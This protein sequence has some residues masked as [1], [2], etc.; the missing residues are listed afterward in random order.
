[1]RQFLTRAVWLTPILCLAALTVVLISPYGEFPLNDDWV[2]YGMVRDMVEH[3]RLAVHPYSSAYAAAQVV[4]AAPIA[5][6]FGLSFTLLRV[7]YCQRLFLFTAGVLVMLAP[8]N[9]VQPVYHDRYIL[10]ALPMF[11]ILAAA[12]LPARV[13]AIKPW[14]AASA[15]FRPSSSTRSPLQVSRITWHGTKRVGTPCTISGPPIRSATITSMAGTS[16]TAFT[17]ANGQS[18]WTTPNGGTRADA[19]VGL[20]RTRFAPSGCAV[21]RERS[22]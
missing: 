21:R 17:R 10:P 16:S 15:R 22:R 6:L 11:A 8:I 1:M 19:T 9:A 4:L 12:A 7:R 14:A 18:V 2:Y 5:F 3:G 20:T 13:L